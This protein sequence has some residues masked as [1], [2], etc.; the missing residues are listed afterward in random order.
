MKIARPS[1]RGFART[2]I[3]IYI[4]MIGVGAALVAPIVTRILRQEPV[5]T[6]N[7]V[8]LAAGVLFVILGAVPLLK[9]FVASCREWRRPSE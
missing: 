1:E 9:W 8:L 3:M 5:T 6:W 4:A 7:W 2:E